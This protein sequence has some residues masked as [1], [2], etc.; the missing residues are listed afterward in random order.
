MLYWL[1]RTAGSAGRLYYENAHAQDRP[2]EPTTVPIGLAGFGG[3]FSGIRR[4]AERDHTN[5]VSWNMYPERRSL[6]GPQGPERAG[7]RHAGLLSTAALT[8]FG[9]RSRRPA[10]V[11]GFSIQLGAVRVEAPIISV[12]TAALAA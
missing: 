1:T 9:M 5:I 8:L 2:T 11:G 6:R 4:F 7:R 3:D 10:R 12:R